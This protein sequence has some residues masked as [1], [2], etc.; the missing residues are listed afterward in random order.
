[1][2]GNDVECFCEVE[3]IYFLVRGNVEGILFELFVY[4][5]KLVVFCMDFVKVI[6][7]FF[8]LYGLIE[9]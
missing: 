9:G 1:M 8:F 5:C 2:D 3:E 6:S 4:N 7:C